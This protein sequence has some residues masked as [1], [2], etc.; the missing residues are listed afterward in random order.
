VKFIGLIS[1]TS[2]DGIDA[3]LAGFE[4]GGTAIECA[5]TLPYPQQLQQRLREVTANPETASV[6]DYGELHARVARAFAAAADALLDKAGREAHDVRAIGSHGQTILHAPA[7]DPPFT[8]QLGDPGALAALTGIPVVADFRT[9]DLALGGQGAPLVPAFHRFAFGDPDEDRALVNVGGIAN[10]TLLPCTGTVTGFDTGPG[11]TLLDNWYC[12]H[13]A[14]TFDPS[15]TWAAGGRVQEALLDALLAEAY[16]SAP[17]PKSTGTDYFNGAWLDTRLA[18]LAAVPDPR[19]VQA[20]LAELTAATIARALDGSIPR[21]RVLAVCG[22]GSHNTDLLERLRRRLPGLNVAST[23]RWGIE[24]DW[25]EAASFAWFA[26]ERLAG[27]ASSL[28]AVTGAS[29]AAS[30]GGVYLPAGDGL[31]QL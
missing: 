30:L 22:G 1:G 21:P 18:Q 11:N 25:V 27:R 9:T 31:W 8:L 26:R 20:T 17:A 28:P 5:L 29:A 7:A 6:V 15:G 16:F 23:A 14:G 10:V 24:P 19:D 3:V 4:A 2:L 12:R 13:H